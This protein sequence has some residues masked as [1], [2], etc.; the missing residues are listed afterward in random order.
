M[1]AEMWRQNSTAPNNEQHVK[2]AMK[3][4]YMF[5]LLTQ[6]CPDNNDINDCPDI[7]DTILSQ[8]SRE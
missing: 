5:G 1:E 6:T 2:G 7:N 8:T 3:T 4:K